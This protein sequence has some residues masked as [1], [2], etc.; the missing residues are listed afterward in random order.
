MPSGSSGLAAGGSLFS[1]ESGSAVHAA[2]WSWGS[3][4]LAVPKPSTQRADLHF[5]STRGAINRQSMCIPRLC[6]HIPEKPRSLLCSVTF[7]WGED[8][9][10]VLALG[11]SLVQEC[12]GIFLWTQRAIPS[13]AGRG[14]WPGAV[15]QQ[16]CCW[17]EARLSVF[18]SFLHC[19][20]TEF[21]WTH[22][23]KR[24]SRAVKHCQ[25]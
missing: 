8:K 22:C 11:L 18:C 20:D 5:L 21:Y 16:Q 2:G 17:A 6:N 12:F 19:L 14:L 23:P 3:L 25:R 10:F 15:Q 9:W 24:V 13:H 4:R 7:A 1:A